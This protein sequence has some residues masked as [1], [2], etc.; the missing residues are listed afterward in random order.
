MTSLQLA[1]P[2]PIALLASVLAVAA[3][4]AVLTPLAD[5]QEP[6]GEVLRS[7][8]WYWGPD[9]PP[10]PDEEIPHAAYRAL[11]ENFVN[12]GVTTMDTTWEVEE[13]TNA[14]GE[15]IGNRLTVRCRPGLVCSWNGADVTED[16]EA[17]TSELKQEPSLTCELSDGLVACQLISERELEAG[18]GVRFSVSVGGATQTVTATAETN[19][20]FRA[21]L[22]CGN[23]EGVCYRFSFT[24]EQPGDTVE[25]SD[26]R[27]VGPVAT[28]PADAE[29]GQD[30]GAERY[31]CP[32][33][34]A[35][36]CTAEAPTGAG[37]VAV[38]NDGETVTIDPGNDGVD[39]T[40]E[41]YDY[42]ASAPAR[43]RQEAEARKDVREAV[44]DI[45]ADDM[46]VIQ[47]AN[48]L[49][50]EAQQENAF[51]LEQELW[52][53]GE[54]YTVCFDPVTYTSNGEEI[55]VQPDCVVITPR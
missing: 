55:T 11:A 20:A 12:N 22:T 14:G 13:L 21:S 50:S 15:P 36:T 34:P 29:P 25:L 2:G 8:T 39:E 31:P 37:V 32:G 38:H 35:S 52:D 7:V 47:A 24:P 43:T 1:F 53:R 26:V 9:G 45:P 3:A 33:Q 41:R 42:D 49:Q 27:A 4:L 10:G 28:S 51:S 16:P 18:E 6:E 44:N 40:D 5:A 54:P 17:F 19:D 48:G 30:G 46:V 23:A